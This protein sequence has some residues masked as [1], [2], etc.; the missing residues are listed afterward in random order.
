MNKPKVQSLSSR[1]LRIVS[2][3]ALVYLSI[4]L[5]VMIPTGLNQADKSHNELEQKLVL[6]LSGSAAIAVYVNN[7]EIANEVMGALMLHEEIDAVMLE[8]QDDVSFSSIRVLVDEESLW[9]TA[10]TYRLYS[11][12]DGKPIGTLYIHNNPQVLQQKALAAVLNQ[13]LFV[14]IQFV[15]TV[16]ALIL[17]FERIVGRPL[18]ALAK[19][20]YS[21][22]PGNTDTITTDEVNQKNE[23]GVVV[24]SVN[25]FID[26]S[27]QAIER[28]RELRA[29]IEHWEQYYRNLAEQDVLTGLKNRLG[30]EKYIQDATQ[31]SHYIALLL[32]DL[33]GFKA[34][35]DTYGH[36]AGD[37]ILTQIAIRFSRLQSNSNIPGVVGRIGGDEFVI[38][39][40]LQQQDDKLLAK[41]AAQAIQLASQP[42]VYNQHPISVGCSIGVAVDQSAKLDIE[43]LVHKADQAMYSVKQSNKNDFRF[44]PL[45]TEDS[46]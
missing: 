4:V 12:T 33:D 35:N 11:P 31:S 41:M 27:R 9:E 13:V 39:L 42:V 19:A 37:L 32:V 10:N 5:V 28:E 17:I 8:G 3:L 1:M 23:L 30:C 25:A 24:Q 21:I 38:Y 44:F 6:S 36:A 16:V 7:S 18:T 45:S 40:V 22:K 20:L 34:V 26:S 14:V 29:Q 43:K 46:D 15:V 2:V